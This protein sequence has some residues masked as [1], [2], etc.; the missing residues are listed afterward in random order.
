MV[1]WAGTGTRRWARLGPTSLFL[2]GEAN[3]DGDGARWAGVEILV[4]LF[5]AQLKLLAATG[6]PGRGHFE[7]VRPLQHDLAGNDQRNVLELLL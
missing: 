5:Q 7:G 3:A 2:R 6:E 4:L 1:G